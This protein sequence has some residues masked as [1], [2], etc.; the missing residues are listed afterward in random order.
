MANDKPNILLIMADQMAFDVI[1]ALGHPVVQTPNLDRLADNGAIFGNCYC[2]SPLCTPSRASFMTGTYVRNN[3]VFDNGAELT[4][5]HPTLMHHLNV[6]GYDTILAGKMHFVGPDQLHG[7]TERLTTDIYPADFG[8]SPDWSLGVCFNDGTGMKKLKRSGECKWNDQMAYDEGVL[9]ATL[10]KIRDMGANKSD[11]PF[12]LCAS[13]THPHDPFLMTKEFLALYEKSAIPLPNAPAANYSDMHPYNQWIQKHHGNDTCEITEEDIINSRRAYYAMVTY[14]DHMV[15]AITNELERMGLS[16]NTLIAITSDHGE[17]LGEHGMWF[18]RTFYDHSAKVPLI[19]SWP[20]NIK[21]GAKIDEVVSL[22]DLTATFME[23]GQVNERGI[24]AND[25]D[26][27]SLVPLLT[28]NGGQWKNEAL[29]EYYGEGPIHS[30]FMYRRGIY[31]YVYV[32]KHEPLL[33][34]LERDP[35]ETINLARE[36]AYAHICRELHEAA[37]SGWDGDEMDSMVLESQRKRKL[38]NQSMSASGKN[39]YGWDYIPINNKIPID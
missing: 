24:W 4:A 33:F 13:F 32:H 34:D 20:G 1:G 5:S 25:M 30:M 8:W 31:K 15:G 12:F 35:H 21:H 26:G 10:S 11:K 38:I 27:D 22:V 14:F 18:K 7:F 9:Y 37:A 2:N 17:M 23:I 36:P 39:D 19:I 6:A 3:M 28:G 16:D 29:C